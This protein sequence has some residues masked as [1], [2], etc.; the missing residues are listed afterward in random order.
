MM[1]KFQ[2]LMEAAVPVKVVVDTTADGTPFKAI[3][4]VI[5][6]V[7]RNYIEVDRST[8]EDEKS[9]YKID[10]A[11]VIIPMSR[12]VEVVYYQSE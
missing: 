2:D 9:K 12:I 3:R 4:G 8:S 1:N 6:H 10:K 5:V 7:G 11:R